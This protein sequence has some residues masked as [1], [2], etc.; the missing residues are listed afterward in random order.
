MSHKL[1][2]LAAKM[3]ERYEETAEREKEKVLLQANNEERD[4]G[5]TPGSNVCFRAPCSARALRQV[6]DP[7]PP[8]R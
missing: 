4:V 1:I 7:A 6:I 3:F 2:Q 8:G 5:D